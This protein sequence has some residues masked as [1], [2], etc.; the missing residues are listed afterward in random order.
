[1]KITNNYT[2]TNTETFQG[3]NNPEL[4]KKLQNPDKDFNL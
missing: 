2:L 1:M 4:V 3:K